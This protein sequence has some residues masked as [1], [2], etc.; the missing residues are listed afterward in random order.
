MHPREARLYTLNGTRSSPILPMVQQVG[1]F[2][3]HLRFMEPAELSL[4]IRGHSLKPITHSL[5]GIQTKPE[6]VHRTD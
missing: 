1:Q 6:R 5:D 3:P 2:Q 4:A